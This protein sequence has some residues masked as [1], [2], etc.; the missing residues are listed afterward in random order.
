MLEGSNYFMYPVGGSSGPA[1]RYGGVAYMA[2]QFGAW[3]A[4]AAEATA[5]GYEVAW[6]VA[7]ADQYTVWNTDGSGNYLSNAIGVV[8]VR[9]AGLQRSE[10]RRVGE[11]S[12]SR[13]AP[14]H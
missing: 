12:R 7:G 14:Q 8:A 3:A 4:R 5:G 1:L 6:K 9:D 13:W 2:G 10:E 11:E